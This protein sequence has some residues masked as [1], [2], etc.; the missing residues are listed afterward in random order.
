MLSLTFTIYFVG[1]FSFILNRFHLML[2]LMSIEFMYLSLMVMFFYN[3]MMLSIINVFVFLTAIVCEA[4]IGLSLLVMISFYY[5]NE[6]TSSFNLI[7]C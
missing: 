2:L 7:K 4:S 5:G 1:I 3:S 6:M